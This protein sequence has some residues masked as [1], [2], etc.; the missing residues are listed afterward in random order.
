MHTTYAVRPQTFGRETLLTYIR[1]AAAVRGGLS[2]HQSVTHPPQEGR[3]KSEAK[4][5]VGKGLI[6]DWFAY[7][8]Q[9]GERDVERVCTE[10]RDRGVRRTKPDYF[11]VGG[12]F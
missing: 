5:S 7:H 2:T 8:R 6:I 3:G 4:H 11:I 1:C 9:H 12:G 10:S